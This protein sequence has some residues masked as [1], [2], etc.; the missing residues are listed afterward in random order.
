MALDEA[1][2]RLDEDLVESGLVDFRIAGSLAAGEFRCS[3]CGYGAIV[4]HELPACPMCGGAV[5]ERAEHG[6]PFNQ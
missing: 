2:S 6:R 4:H 5:W 3:D 1:G